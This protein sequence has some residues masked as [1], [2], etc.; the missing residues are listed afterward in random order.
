[1]AGRRPRAPS[2][3]LR[4]RAPVRGGTAPRRG[5][6]RAERRRRARSG[7]GHR[8]LR[9]HRPERREDRL[10]RDP[11]RVHGHARPSRLDRRE[12]RRAGPGRCSRRHGRTERRGRPGRA[13]RLPRAPS[14][15]RRPGLRGSAGVPA[16]ASGRRGADRPG[17][18]DSG[19]GTSRRCRIRGR[20]S[21]TRAD[22]RRH[23][24]VRSCAGRAA[25][26][27]GRGAGRR[28][29]RCDSS[30]GRSGHRRRARAGG[31]DSARRRRPRSPRFASRPASDAATPARGPRR[32]TAA[33]GT[34]RGGRREAP[35]SRFGLE[36]AA[37]GA[38]AGGSSRGASPRRRSWPPAP[39]KAVRR[40]TYH[41]WR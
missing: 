37:D 30:C 26:G 29:D 13:V 17:R 8:L 7:A 10:D 4:P 39:R 27:R 2:V 9:R 15:G 18:A 5:S 20:R 32:P 23:G 11:L 40:P 33:L 22:G 24:C 25:D 1:V 3:L 28:S 36:R 38:V 31:G 14:D 41:G 19:R 21:L 16:P 34:G 35:G 6:R 12:T